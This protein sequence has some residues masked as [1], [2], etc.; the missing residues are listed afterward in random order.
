MI[1]VSLDWDHA[2]RYVEQNEPM[3]NLVRSI[4]ED[5]QDY[6]NRF[7]VDHVKRYLPTGYFDQSGY[8]YHAMLEDAGTWSRNEV[9]QAM[10]RI[11]AT[12]IAQERIFGEVEANNAF[13]RWVVGDHDT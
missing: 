1:R 12:K 6:M 7:G 8:R 11:A 9:L 10:H 13:E 2:R 3:Q 5:L 4:E